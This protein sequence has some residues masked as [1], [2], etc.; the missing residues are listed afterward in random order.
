M[1]ESTS[2][3]KQQQPT[4]TNNNQQQPTNTNNNQQ[5]HDSDNERIIKNNI[6]AIHI[7][8]VAMQLKM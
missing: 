1:E 8:P 2:N 4:T 7:Y 6:I 5:R 3:N